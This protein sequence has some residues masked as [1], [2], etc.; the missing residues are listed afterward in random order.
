MFPLL[1][2]AAIVFARRNTHL[3]LA[4]VIVTLPMILTAT[5]AI[6]FGIG[7]AIHGF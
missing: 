5:G 3:G 7:V 4:T 2:I 6:L 1:A